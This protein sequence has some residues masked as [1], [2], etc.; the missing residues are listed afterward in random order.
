[1]KRNLLLTPG[2]TQTPPDICS[3]LGK[4]IIHHRTPEFQ[5]NL[6][7]AGKNPHFEY[8]KWDVCRPI[9]ENS[10]SC[11]TN[12]AMYDDLEP[13]YEELPGWSESTFGVKSL[14]DLPD[15]ARNYIRFIEEKIEA[16]VDIISTGP[17]REETIILNHPFD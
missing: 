13:V 7:E 17:D 14:D 6:K 9:D 15:N 3:A 2:P 1:M 12:F 4:P 16:P 8:L 11:L 5:E 10:L